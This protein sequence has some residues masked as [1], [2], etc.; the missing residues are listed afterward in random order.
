MMR[1]VAGVGRG[2]RTGGRVGTA[3]E[4]S[5]TL[6]PEEAAGPSEEEVGLNLLEGTSIMSSNLYFLFA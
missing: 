5:E 1:P 2:F 3:T 6:R 4:L